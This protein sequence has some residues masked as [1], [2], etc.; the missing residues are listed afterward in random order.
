M[1]IST[2]LWYI[3]KTGC[4]ITVS[5]QQTCHTTNKQ[6]QACLFVSLHLITLT[7]YALV[8]EEL[9]HTLTEGKSNFFCLWSHSWFDTFLSHEPSKALTLCHEQMT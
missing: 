5:E 7:N 3:N 6:M 9:V 1:N 8:S 2:L 4:Y